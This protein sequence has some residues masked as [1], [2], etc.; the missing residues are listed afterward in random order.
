MSQ[1]KGL[2]RPRDQQPGMQQGIDLG[3]VPARVLNQQ[4][5]QGQEGSIGNEGENANVR[6]RGSQEVR[7]LLSDL[8][9]DPHDIK[10]RGELRNARNEDIAGGSMVGKPPKARKERGHDRVRFPK[11]V[12]NKGQTLIG[13]VSNVRLKVL[14]HFAANASHGGRGQGDRADADG[15]QNAKVPGAALFHGDI[16]VVGQGAR[17][18]TH[19]VPSE[20]APNVLDQSV[21]LLGGSLGSSRAAAA[22][23]VGSS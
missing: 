7:G 14:D 9:Q 1:G 17:Q 15:P 13:G 12:G 2:H 3:Q 23:V 16:V 21:I 19:G 22:V 5:I 18:G 10:A 8:G 20:E 4:G 6:V 11:E